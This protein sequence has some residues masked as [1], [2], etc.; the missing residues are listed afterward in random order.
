MNTTRTRRFGFLPRSPAAWAA[1]A[2]AVL[3]ACAPAPPPGAG[4]ASAA[5]VEAALNRFD[6]AWEREDLEAA[7]GA[8]TP[9]AVAFDPVP[10][11]RF[12]GAEG[13]RTWISESFASLEQISINLSQVSVRTEGPAAWVTAHFVF[14][15]QQE[16]KPSR[17]E[18]YVSMIWVLQAD[19][20][21]KMSVF[22]ASH[23][24]AATG[25]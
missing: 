13:I 7:A 1:L 23:L 5:E 16:G 11:G 8:F 20:S 18:G 3:A 22:H 15:A 6:E 10:P 2:M 4:G 19:G 14:D 17:A 24:P 25:G 12:E 21:L 9:D